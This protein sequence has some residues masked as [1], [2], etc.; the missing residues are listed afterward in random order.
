MAGATGVQLSR[1]LGVAGSR[2]TFLR[3]L[4]RLP[5]PSF[6]SPT[7]LGVDDFALRKPQR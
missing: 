2:R 6:A 4:R 7:V 1:C 3:V 5:I